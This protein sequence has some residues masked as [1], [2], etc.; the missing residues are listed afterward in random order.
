MPLQHRVSIKIVGAEGQAEPDQ[1]YQVSRNTLDALI[2]H[3]GPIPGFYADVPYGSCPYYLC[4]CVPGDP[5][6]L[7]KCVPC[8]LL[9]LVLVQVCPMGLSLVPM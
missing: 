8:G 4:R 2:S 1:N 7:Y 6:L 5:W 9:Y 3:V